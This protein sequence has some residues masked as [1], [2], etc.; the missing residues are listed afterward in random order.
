MNLTLGDY[1]F[2][3]IAISVG[4]AFLLYLVLDMAPVF[5]IV[6]SLLLRIGIDSLWL[7]LN[8]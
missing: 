2:I 1:A 3:S 7:C 4:V 6:C 8:V 5:T